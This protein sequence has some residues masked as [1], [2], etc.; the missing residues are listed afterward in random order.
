MG[1][2]VGSW[3]KPFHRLPFGITMQFPQKSLLRGADTTWCWWLGETRRSCWQLNY[4]FLSLG[5]RFPLP[6]WG[7]DAR[8]LECGPV[9]ERHVDEIWQVE[10][11]QKS[12][13]CS[14]GGGG[15][16][17]GLGPTDFGTPFRHCLHFR[18]WKFRCPVVFQQPP[19]VL[20]ASN[21]VGSQHF[22]SF[23]NSFTGLSLFLLEIE[24][25]LCF[26]AD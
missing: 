25:F 7:L 11:R 10:E 19:D 4:H 24:W 8:K 9:S 23:V 16:V 21:E 18:C 13:R 1:W 3:S 20:K 17:R 5:L 22:H 15:Q 6:S 12:Q 26:L 14:S 2:G